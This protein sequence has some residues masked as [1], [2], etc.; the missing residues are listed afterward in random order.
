MFQA[1]NRYDQPSIIKIKGKMRKNQKSKIKASDKVRRRRVGVKTVP[2]ADSGGRDHQLAEK[3][4]GKEKI[5]TDLSHYLPAC[6]SLRLWR[7]R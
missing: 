7:L 6:Q 2:S 3:S 5:A 4:I 1:T